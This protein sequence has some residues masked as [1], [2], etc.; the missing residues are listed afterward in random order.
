MD[1][2]HV[3]TKQEL[4]EEYL[5]NYSDWMHDTKGVDQS[6][7]KPSFLNRTLV[8]A[9]TVEKNPLAFAKPQLRYKIQETSYHLYYLVGSEDAYCR[10][11]CKT[12]MEEANSSS[13]SRWHELIAQNDHLS[14]NATQVYN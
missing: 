14:V 3:P 7:L 13:S 2:E 6:L 4:Y 10:Q 12:V 5:V 8:A 1:K 9:A 11:A